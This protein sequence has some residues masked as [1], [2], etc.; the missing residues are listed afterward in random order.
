MY[1]LL[2]LNERWCSGG[3]ESLWANLLSFMPQSAF[4]VVVLVW[5][6][7]TD[8]YDDLL[9][10]KNV[11]IVVMGDGEIYHPIK[12]DLLILHSLKKYF[13]AEKAD[14]IHINVCNAIGLKYA[15]IAYK[16]GC[17]HV[18]VHS[19]NTKIE[20]DAFRIKLFMHY[21]MRALYTDKK[22][23]YIACSREAG[24]FMFGKKR[25]FRLFKNGIN[26]ERFLYNEE[27]RLFFRKKYHLDE[28][29]FVIC[30]VGR[31]AEQKNHEYLIK[32]FS[33]I[34]NQYQDSYLFLIGE[35]PEKSHICDLVKENG[36]ENSVIFMGTVNNV[37]NIYFMSD[38]FILPSLHEGLPVVAIE[39]QATG[40]NTYLADTI[41]RE[42]CLTEHCHF[43]SLDDK[44]DNI[45]KMVLQN[46]N[47]LQ[48]VD[49]INSIIKA[50]YSIEEESHNLF[51]KYQELLET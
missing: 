51:K 1:K 31:F 49:A 40:L 27:K 17:K 29:D 25:P 2:V 28:Q 16:S 32:L 13:D 47:C 22:T 24:T 30:H 50:G 18:V 44:P 33:V 26:T 34:K 42:T 45:A 37:E 48:R 8:I 41:S 46:R 14:I 39:A 6:K 23:D 12:R 3:V 43:F 4:E 10:K 38:C 15:K 21:I 9:K 5:Q 35:G 11:R 36:L 7:E 19:H 20:H